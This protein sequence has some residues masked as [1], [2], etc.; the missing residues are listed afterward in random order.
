MVGL[1]WWLRRSRIRL[2][3]WRP[4]FSPWI[5][6]I[7]WRREMATHSSILAWRISWTEKPGRPQS[8][9]SLRVRGDWVTHTLGHTWALN[10]WTAQAVFTSLADALASARLNSSRLSRSE[11]LS[12][13]ESWESRSGKQRRAGAASDTFPS[14]GVCCSASREVGGSMR[15][16]STQQL[17]LPWTAAG[18]ATDMY[19]QKWLV[20]IPQPSQRRIC[21]VFITLHEEQGAA[22]NRRF[23]SQRATHHPKTH[24]HWRSE[25]S[26]VWSLW[27][28]LQPPDPPLPVCLRPHQ[29][30]GSA[31]SWPS[32][33]ADRW[34]LLEE[35]KAREKSGVPPSFLILSPGA[36]L[37]TLSLVARFP[38]KC[39]QNDF[40]AER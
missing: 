2:Q 35:S 29:L 39:F 23:H 32:P 9:G 30:S 7:P 37:C 34:P 40:S 15:G 14:A 33:P 8:M 20:R 38:A 18:K 21:H 27:L 13:S 25:T 3:F 5:G 22:V 11:R 10:C 1:P 16:V 4:G 12:G 26:R 24:T 31:L 17:R 19:I 28:V 6:K 36:R